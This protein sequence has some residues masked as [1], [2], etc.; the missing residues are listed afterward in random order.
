M[1]PFK[2]VH[3]ADLHLDSPFKG[4]SDA[5]IPPDVLTAMKEA[6]FK[7]F[8]NIVE[9]CLSNKVDALLIAGDIYDSQDRS[10]KAQRR[11]IDGLKR[12]SDAGIKSY[13]CHGNH[14]PLDGWKSSLTFPD[15]CYQFNSKCGSY[16]ML[17]DGNET[18]VVHGVSYPTRVVTKNLIPGFNKLNKGTFNI[19][20][21]HANVDSDPNH[22]P[23]AP[24][25]LKDLEDTGFDYW[26]LGHV[27]NRKIL[28]KKS[29]TVVYPG[30]SQGRHNREPGK[31]GVYLINVDQ[32]L[33]ISYEFSP[34]DV[35]RWESINLDARQ[36]NT[37]QI[38]EDEIE[39]LF[40]SVLDNNDRRNLVVRLN[41]NGPTEVHKELAFGGVLQDIQTEFNDRWG[42]QDPFLWCERIID[43]TSNPINRDKMSK[44]VDFTGELIRLVNKI[45]DGP[46]LLEEI[47][48]ESYRPVKKGKVGRLL[49][50]KMPTDGEFLE[51][52]NQA[53]N[54]CLD[55]LLHGDDR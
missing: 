46:D 41:I 18:V 32:Y 34:T 12:L 4:F 31:K 51:I 7:S 54:F 19:G 15:L 47:K 14:D 8:N 39:K 33:G 50:D 49:R 24:C 45:S 10:Y 5:N 36:I 1:K 52:V 37:L 11:F 3:A 20:L 25:S 40:N 9:L 30:N 48:E 35:L 23:Y 6:T 26:A 13:I 16:T 44:D 21:I 43:T 42:L 27:H 29:P 22:D 53:E 28:K 38:L 17:D 2:F 55:A